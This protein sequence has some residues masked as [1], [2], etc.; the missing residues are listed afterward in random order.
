[1]SDDSQQGPHRNSKAR[2]ALSDMKRILNGER[3]LPIPGNPAAKLLESDNLLPPVKVPEERYTGT[4]EDLINSIED[5]ASKT[6]S[7]V[8]CWSA[9]KLMVL[10][11]YGQNYW[12]LFLEVVLKAEYACERSNQLISDHFRKISNA[13]YGIGEFGDDI[14]VTRY[15]AYLIAQNGDARKKQVAYAQTYFATQARKQELDQLKKSGTN[16]EQQRLL[17]R[18]RIAEHNKSLADAARD[19]G[20][21]LPLDFAVFQN[22]GYK[23]LYNGLDVSGI[24]NAKGLTKNAKIL[25]HMGI[26]ELAANFFR[27]TQAEDKLR[28]DGIS[29]KFEA[30]AAHHE[31]GKKVRKAIADIGGVM[32]ENLAPAED[33]D[34]VRKRLTSTD[35]SLKIKK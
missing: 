34:L 14:Q 27:A 10:L 12:E 35:G 33:I 13:S 3:P 19:A 22:F 15:G 11:G 8:E 9:R 5:S 23:G 16:E 7:G 21:L 6:S 1:M 25:D 18:D 30:N 24:R 31:V 17:M 2:A 28:R 26:T 20:V 32:P 29:G 4:I